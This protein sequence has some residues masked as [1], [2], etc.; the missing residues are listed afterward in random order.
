MVLVK[1]IKNPTVRES[2]D[3]VIHIAI[4]IVVAMLITRFVFQRTVVYKKSMEPTLIEGDNLI[5]EKISPKLGKIERGDIVTVYAPDFVQEK[6]STMIKRV[7]GIEGDKI[8]ITDG[9]VYVNGEAIE[10][11][12]ILGDSTER[13]GEYVELTVEEDH[14]YVLG[15]NRVADIVDSRQAGQISIDNI[16]GKAIIRLYPFNKIRLF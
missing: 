7:I 12:Y 10:E 5:V 14:Y 3:W 1:K 6:G 13:I 15:D 16:S 4:A 11:D 2:V 8:N 9:D